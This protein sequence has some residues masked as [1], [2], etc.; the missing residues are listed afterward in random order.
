[1]LVVEGSDW[2]TGMDARCRALVSDGLKAETCYRQ[3]IDDLGRTPMR[4]E[5][6]RAHLLYGEFLRQDA[7]RAEARE[8]LHV[9][10]ARFRTAGAAA[11]AERARAELLATGEKV[12]QREV[13]TNHE[14]TTQ[15]EHIARLARDGRSNTE[16]G[17][18]LFISRR[19][20]EWHMR[21]IFTKLGITSRNQLRDALPASSR[22][23][24][25]GAIAASPS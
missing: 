8:H 6:A 15:E 14:L 13:G 10:Y 11:F 4:I 3:A 2:A 22:H 1:M 7:R 20:V 25:H 21:K 9:A 23:G 18:E 19:T 24:T 12:S 17:A 5:L 16:I